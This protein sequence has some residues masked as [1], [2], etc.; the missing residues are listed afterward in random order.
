[1]FVGNERVWSWLHL[2]YNLHIHIQTH[3]QTQEKT[4]GLLFQVR[5]VLWTFEFGS[6]T[7]GERHNSYYT[8]HTILTIPNAQRILWC[9]RSPPVEIRKLNSSTEWPNPQLLDF[10]SQLPTDSFS[11][12]S[13]FQDHLF[14]AWHHP[15][16]SHISCLGFIMTLVIVISFACE[17]KTVPNDYAPE[18]LTQIVQSPT[19]LNDKI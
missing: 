18:L 14:R 13:Y 17:R 7:R 6:S 5:T 10:Q 16:S 15:H 3:M 4:G 19:K 11:K 2:L 8:D 12:S 9:L 1:M